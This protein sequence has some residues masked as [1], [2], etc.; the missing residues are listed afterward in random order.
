M[1]HIEQTKHR[2][3]RERGS[4]VLIMLTIIGLGA[5]FML[6]SALNKANSQIER[7]KITT[8]ALAQAKEALIGWSSARGDIAGNPRP[9]ELP[10]PDTNAPGSANYGTEAG[11]CLAGRIGRLPW[12]TLGIEEPKDGYGETLWYAIDGSFRKRNSNSLPIN[13]DTRATMQI[14][15]HDGATL[16]TPPGYEA[17]AI[18]F[19]P[20]AILATQLRGAGQQ[21]TASN[22]LDN[23][24]PPTIPTPRNNAT[25]NGPFIQGPVKDASGNVVVNDRL[26][27]IAARDLMPV[28]EKRVAK[29][30]K[31][32][33]GNYYSANSSKYPNPAAYND[34]DCRDVGTSGYFTACPSPSYPAQCRGRVPEAA[35]SSAPG[36][37]TYNLWGQVIYYAVGTSYLAAVP[38]NCGANLTV[39]GIAGTKGL[40]IMPGTPKGAIVRNAPNQSII[41]GD[42]LEDATNQDGWTA[43]PPNTQA[44]ADSYLTPSAS[45]NDTM[46]ILP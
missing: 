22:Y 26:L 45:S 44:N 30:L 14:Y 16:L 31:T 46:H 41:L 24:G 4:A 18:I 39:N 27:V 37:F 28:I 36:W 17:V 3:R 32:L 7:D 29:E 19:S 43:I 13:S 20:G 1:T 12:K 21:T 33:L 6:V 11:A 10:C 38:A 35:L 40:F 34:P 23:T 2:H 5:A 25:I 8:A 9:G 42:Y 15:D